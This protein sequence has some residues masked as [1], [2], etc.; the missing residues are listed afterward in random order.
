MYLGCSETI[1]SLHADECHVCCSKQQV[2][3][4]II[5]DFAL[6]G[7]GSGLHF[8]SHKRVTI[9]DIQLIRNCVAKSL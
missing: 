6:L 1:P 7:R 4:Q 5:M 8:F 3:E 9:G 2:I